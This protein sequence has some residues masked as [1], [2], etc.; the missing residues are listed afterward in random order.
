MTCRTIATATVV[1]LAMS[2]GK[3]IA[4]EPDPANPPRS[5]IAFVPKRGS[6]GIW[7]QINHNQRFDEDVKDNHLYKGVMFGKA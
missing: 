1:V 4:A 7:L 2:A 3:L 5:A 6:F